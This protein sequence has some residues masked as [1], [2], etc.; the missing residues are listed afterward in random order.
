MNIPNFFSDQSEIINFDFSYL[1]NYID[2]DIDFSTIIPNLSPQI[3]KKP[4]VF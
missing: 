3:N 2:S 4:F 1:Q